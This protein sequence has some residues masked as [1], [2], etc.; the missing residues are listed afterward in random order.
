MAL[1]VETFGTFPAPDEV[2]GFWAHDKQHAPRPLSPLAKELVTDTL[3]IGFTRAHAEMGASVDMTNRTVNHYLYSSLVPV[4]DP[5]EA[6][7]RAAAYDDVLDA[8]LPR[9]GERWEHEWKPWLVAKVTEGR[10]AD[11]RGAT[12]AELVAELEAQRRHMIEQWTIHGHIN[13]IVVASARFCDFYDECFSPA[14]PTEA[15]QCLQGFVTRS[16]DAS[17]GLWRL[18]RVVR[19]QPGLRALWDGRPAAE[20][21][22]ALPGVPGGQA[23]LDELRGYLDEFG[24]RSDAVYDVADVTWREDPSIPLAA[25]GGYLGLD[26]DHDPSLR[27]DAAVRRREGLL[28]E[29]RRR[30]AD[31]PERL[32]RFD[33]LYDAARHNMPIT[34]D[35][36][37]WIDQSGI[38]NFRRFLLQVGDRLVAD[39][40]LD[41]ASDVFFLCQDEVADALLHGGD[42][43][44]AAAAR[45]A[46]VAAAA[47][48]SPPRTLGN[49][50]APR[51]P[52]DPL[53]DALVVRL[54]GRRPPD[55]SAP[56]AGELKGVAASP[57]TATGTARVV[58]SLAE[59]SKLAPGDIM[60]CEMTLP[61]WVPLFSLVAGVVADTG[62]VLSHCAIVAREYGV[63]AVVGTLTGT[64]SI[65]DGATV[66]VDGDRGL[67]HTHPEA[68]VID[69]R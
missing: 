24:W 59:A 8:A 6:A 27:L 11:H 30:L 66:T 5:T 37:F 23:F 14:D 13:F 64:S 69:L 42:R 35:H 53:L 31:Q 7:R 54:S 52:L 34:E 20:I 22:S 39:G 16:V 56:V 28:A 21:L 3:A 18:S 40:V 49:P 15:Y 62:G 41:D 57:G 46:E 12:N 65:V 4:A 60:V 2:E 10:N 61:P 43:R 17:Q 45:R 48:L 19:A 51:G 47:E 50:P 63:P 9:L 68:P 44:D 32:A 26:D 1:S 55:P 29:A 58:R 38:A 36:A 25:L 67:V 33:V